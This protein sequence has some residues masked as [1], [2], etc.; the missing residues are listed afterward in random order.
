MNGF[1]KKNKNSEDIQENAI[2]HQHESLEEISKEEKINLNLNDFS[3]FLS[4]FFG[5]IK[6]ATNEYCTKLNQILETIKVP[7]NN[8][9][10]KNNPEK[11]LEKNLYQVIKDIIEI[12]SND[13]FNINYEENKK[14]GALIKDENLEELKVIL[15]LDL[16]K[17]IFNKSAYHQEFRS[18]E[19]ILIE[20]ELKEKEVK[21]SISNNKIN[22]IL[23]LQEAYFETNNKLKTGLKSIFQIIIAQRK[24]LIQNVIEKYKLCIKNINNAMEKIKKRT[25]EEKNKKFN[26]QDVNYLEALDKKI[27]N[28]FKLDIYDFKFLLRYKAT[29]EDK[30]E[31]K[32][33]KNNYADLFE[34]LSNLDED[35]IEKIAEKIEKIPNICLSQKNQQKLN[36]IKDKKN[37]EKKI[38]LILNTP[39][40][41]DSKKLENFLQKLK[42]SSQNQLLFLE[43]LNNHRSKGEIVLKKKS[44]NIISEIFLSML[45]SSTKKKDSKIIQLIIILSQ[46]YYHEE[47]NKKEYIVNIIH[48]SKVFKEKKF[49]MDYLKC[50]LEE[51]MLKVNN[52]NS[53]KIFE[54]KMSSMFYTT[55]LTV[56]KNMVD[57]NLGM[58]FISN[59]TDEAYDIY[60]IPDNQKKDIINYLIEEMKS[61]K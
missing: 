31:I 13:L 16:E 12:L 23:Q 18:Y 56:T 14:D 45:D 26:F 27:N 24:N 25:L 2:V 40:K 8:K 3:H 35:S 44:L 29:N 28:I 47:K 42:S 1:L 41:L 20:S 11:E 5:K 10:I 50:L 55:I 49:W 59:V 61:A 36:L 7:Q 46:T 38:I 34:L 54:K 33:D 19:Q 57:F 52:I 32:K 9:D 22:T 43:Y 60:N 58:D 30:K 4:D 48:T 53:Q 15:N 51:E 37:I 6:I 17:I 21:N 39:E